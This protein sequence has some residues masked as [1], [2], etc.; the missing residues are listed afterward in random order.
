MT[1]RIGTKE[2]KRK[3]L[4]IDIENKRQKTDKDYD[5]T[6]LYPSSAQPMPLE[7][8]DDIPFTYDTYDTPPLTVEQFV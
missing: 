3:L 1:R 8:E 5:A 2:A 7:I 6:S 4:E